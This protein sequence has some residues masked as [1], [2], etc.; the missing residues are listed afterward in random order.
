M[1]TDHI[2]WRNEFGVD[3]LYDNFEY[4]ELAQVDKLYP[5]FYHKTDKVRCL[6]FSTFV[7]LLKRC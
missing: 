3:D 6:R 2:K 1:W 7:S 5:Q 4:P